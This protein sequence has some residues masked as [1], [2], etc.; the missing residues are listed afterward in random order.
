MESENEILPEKMQKALADI[1][2]HCDS[3][4]ILAST[5]EEG[6]TFLTHRYAGSFHTVMGMLEHYKAMKLGDKIVAELRG[7]EEEE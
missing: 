1:A 4:I 2:E 6:F 5:T 3:V 7:E